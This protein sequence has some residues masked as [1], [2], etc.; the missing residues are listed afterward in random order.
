MKRASLRAA[1]A[2]APLVLAAS[3]I[4]QE[5]HPPPAAPVEIKMTAKK[6]EFSPA[7]ITVERGRP[8]RLLITAL[9]TTHGIEIKELGVKVE[10]ERGKETVVELTPDRVGTFPFKCSNF[11]GLGHGRMKGTLVVVEPSAP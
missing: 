3:V 7:T 2:L 6:Y 10:L 4:G 8:I 11:C 9:D 1:L 5:Q